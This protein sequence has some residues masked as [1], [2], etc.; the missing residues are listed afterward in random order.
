MTYKYYD[1]NNKLIREGDWLKHI[2]GDEEFVFETDNG[3]L[4]FDCT[5]YDFFEGRGIEPTTM[6]ISLLSDYDL[7]E[8]E[9][10]KK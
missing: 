3:D 10:I 5:N 1:K 7:S 4:G 9:I 2:D 6:Y 8:W